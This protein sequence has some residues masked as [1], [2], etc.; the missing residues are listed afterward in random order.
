MVND[1]DIT[2]ITIYHI[3]L[4]LVISCLYIENPFACD[5]LAEEI[6]DTKNIRYGK[7][8]R[9]NSR[10]DLFLTTAGIK[11]YERDTSIMHRLIVLESKREPCEVVE[12][13]VRR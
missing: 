10:H 12:D 13:V 4:L 3:Y 7:D 11:C 1:D 6:F 2:Q 8:Y 9:V 5:W